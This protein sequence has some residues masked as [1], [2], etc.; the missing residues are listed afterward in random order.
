MR[1]KYVTLVTLALFAVLIVSAWLA[2][3]QAQ[4]VT[5]GVIAG[6]SFEYEILSVTGNGT[7]FSPGASNFTVTVFLVTGSVVNFQEAI[8]YQD[9][10]NP[11]VTGYTDLSNGSSEA[12]RSWII[13]PANLSAGDPVYPGW[14]WIINGT[15][16]VTGRP[17][18]YLSLKNAY[19]N[20]SGQDAYVTA[21][22]YLDKATG[23]MVNATVNAKSLSHDFQFTES[24]TLIEQNVWIPVPEFSPTILGATIVTLTACTAV[25]C[26]RKAKPQHMKRKLA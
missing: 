11:F 8:R 15:V 3:V 21:D 4:G 19:I 12:G 9:G 2:L 22:I 10:T 7:E 1:G 25:A 13:V 17:T 16:T 24:Y 14:N 18:N 26:N 6:N 23:A 20:N 5:V